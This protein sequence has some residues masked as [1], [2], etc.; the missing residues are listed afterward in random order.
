MTSSLLKIFLLSLITQ[1]NVSC[2]DGWDDRDGSSAATPN[3]PTDPEATKPLYI[4]VFEPI[5]LS[6]SAAADSS[7]FGATGTSQFRITEWSTR[8]AAATEALKMVADNVTVVPRAI[9]TSDCTTLT[10][11]ETAA[12]ASDPGSVRSYPDDPLDR[13]IVHLKAVFWD[14]D[15]GGTFT[16]VVETPHWAA[17]R[18]LRGRGRPAVSLHYFSVS[19]PTTGHFAHWKASTDS[20]IVKTAT[21][22]NTVD[23]TD[24]GTRA[25]TATASSDALTL[26]NWAVQT[27]QEVRP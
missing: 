20:K 12:A 10:A 23:P 21:A 4:V 5:N 8:I 25:R 11:V 14:T 26:A 9:T 1:I 18:T 17:W 7:C 3:I 16:L 15:V 13:P 24:A 22:I 2:Y 27:A 19:N 6:N